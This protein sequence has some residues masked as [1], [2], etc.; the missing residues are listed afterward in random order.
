MDGKKLVLL[1]IKA[2]ERSLVDNQGG[3]AG[4]HKVLAFVRGAPET[5]P[6]WLL[7]LLMEQRR[8]FVRVKVE[9]TQRNQR[10]H[11]MIPV[12]ISAA[13]KCEELAF[14]GQG[15]HCSDALAAPDPEDRRRVNFLSGLGIQHVER[16]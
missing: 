10:G 3:A 14:F 4:D 11:A 2:A 13:I 8:D 12:A 5:I 7:S 16:P 6:Q 15:G 1:Q 9:Q